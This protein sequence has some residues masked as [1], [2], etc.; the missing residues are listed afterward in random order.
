MREERIV[1]YR[2]H[3]DQSRLR[4]DA[5][6]VRKLRQILNE[7]IKKN[8]SPVDK[9]RH[10]IVPSFHYKPELKYLNVSK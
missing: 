6:F 7:L 5:H 1:V 8:L 3:E 4:K 9:A 2:T 10:I